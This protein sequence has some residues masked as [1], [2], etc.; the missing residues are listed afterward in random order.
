MHENILKN[1]ACY[2]QSTIIYN[3]MKLMENSEKNKFF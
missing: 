2:M 1:V 3:E